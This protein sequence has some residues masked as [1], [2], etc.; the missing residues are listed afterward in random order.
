MR[1]AF[2]GLFLAL[3]AHPAHALPLPDG[4]IGWPFEA[5]GQ[6]PTGG[7]VHTIV[8]ELRFT[9]SSIELSASFDGIEAS[10]NGYVWYWVRSDGS[11]PGSTD[12]L[13]T[14]P[15]APSLVGA[16]ILPESGGGV[17]WGSGQLE[18]EL[19]APGNVLWDPSIPAF[20]PVPL[21]AP[22]AS[23]FSVK[24]LRVFQ[25]RCVDTPGVGPD[26][27]CSE[28][29]GERTRVEQLVVDIDAFH[30][31]VPAPEAGVPALLVLGLAGV[32]SARRVA[33]SYSH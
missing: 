9:D 4:S 2:L 10:M 26:S 1:W 24:Q 19:V 12:R 17:Y 20:L 16:P 6:A 31:P 30:D 21:Y 13:S 27:F 5:H 8:G 29:G 28:G 7:P 25:E 23:L 33:A 18:I 32:A 11:G 15:N 3:A 14:L 22:D